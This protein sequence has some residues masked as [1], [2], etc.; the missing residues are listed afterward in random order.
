MQAY[1]GMD[2]GTAKPS[3]RMLSRIPHHLLSFLDPKVQ[4][5]AGE[6]VKRAERL[7]S[8]IHQRDKLPVVSGGTAFY[9]RCF[10]FGLPES[11]EG[12]GRL[13]SQ[14][15]SQERE[16]GIE[17][18][19]EDLRRKDPAAAERIPP[20]DRYRIQRALEIF[21]STGKSV[22]SFAWPGS[23]RPDYD[24]TIIGLSR[25]REDLYARIDARVDAMFGEGLVREVS[26]LMEAGYS[27]E[28]P[29]MKAIG[30]RE[31]FEMRRG[32]M[33]FADV[34]AAVQ[35][36]SRRYAKRQMT[37][38]RSIPD[39]RWVDAG[40]RDGLRAEIAAFQAP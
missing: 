28:D 8:E 26:G 9:I 18:L 38:F 23:I 1:K 10:L 33:T 14:F 5:T 30:Y 27:A 3:P 4:Y 34:K 32:C 7:V 6:F 37:F 19:Y 17:A 29:G 12:D 22:Y 35:R 21:E 16:A 24:F 40:D 15:K 25:P 39:V 13:R 11:P 31:F 2:I 20:A 36:D